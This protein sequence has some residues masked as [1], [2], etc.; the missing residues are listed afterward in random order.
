MISRAGIS[1][2]VFGNKIDA[3]NIVI[4]NGVLTEYETAVEQG[5]IIV[6]VGCTGYAA[7]EIWDKI[8]DNI[9]EFYPRVDEMVAKAFKSLNE[10]GNS[11]TK[12]NS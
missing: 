8:N 11:A 12:D 5:N 9:V 4:A 10:K 3:G 7:K 2:F 1:I 6:P